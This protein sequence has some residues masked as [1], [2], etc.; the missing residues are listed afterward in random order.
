MENVRATR[1]RRML[2]FLRRRLGD[3]VVL[4]LLVTVL[5]IVV[6]PGSA[7][8]LDF[9]MAYVLIVFALY[10]AGKGDR[11]DRAVAVAAIIAFVLVELRIL[12]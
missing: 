5:A 6:L 3:L 10:A 2:E 11:V 4:A 9:V 8:W 7:Y 1:S 12:R